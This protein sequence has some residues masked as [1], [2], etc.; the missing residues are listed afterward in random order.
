MGMRM[1]SR[2]GS[3]LIRLIIGLAAAVAFGSALFA[4]TAAAAKPGATTG[5]ADCGSD[6]TFT[7]IVTENNGKLTPALL[8]GGG[9]FIPS[10]I[11]NLH[12]EFTDNKGNTQPFSDPDVERHA[13]ANKNL[14][15]CHF[16]F[17]FADENGSGFVEGDATGFIPGRR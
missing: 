17:T 9:V 11:K 3:D 4:G 2:K 7:F 15:T 8:E 12:G 13:P 1:G 16:R 10:A 5:V 6:G 14:M